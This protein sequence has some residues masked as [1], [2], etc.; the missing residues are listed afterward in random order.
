MLTI[1]VPFSFSLGYGNTYVDL[2]PAEH[3][4]SF[5]LSEGTHV[6]QSALVAL[7]N[8]HRAGGRRLLGQFSFE[9]TYAPD[10]HTVTVC[11]TE[12]DSSRS[13]CLSTMP[14]G[15]DEICR[16]RLASG[17]FRDDDLERNPL[18]NYTTSLTPGLRDVFDDTLRAVNDRLILAL[19]RAG[20]NVQVRMHPPRLPAESQSQFMVVYRHGE[21]RGLHQVGMALGTDDELY[22]IESV[23]GGEVTL[24][25]NEAF[26]NVIGSTNDPK[27]AGLS[28]IQLWANQYNVYPVICTSYHSHGF[29][30][31]NSLVGGHVIGGTVAKK[32]AKGS[33]SVW[34][35]PICIQHNNDDN[36]SMEALRYLKGIWL[37]NYLGS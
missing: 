24:S 16:Q 6:A 14:E 8:V 36:V 33:N 12:F 4:L 26:A 32:I 35:F 17:G 28:W 27:I 25:Y 3:T 23:F 21:F 19:E 37:K 10:T 1:E 7:G 2:N 29:G 22:T 13:L 18:W 5:A 31:G 9:Y 30:C 34:I 15:T 11:G 20:L